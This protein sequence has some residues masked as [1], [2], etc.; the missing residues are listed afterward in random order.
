MVAKYSRRQFPPD[1]EMVQCPDRAGQI[2]AGHIFVNNKIII[3]N[4]Q[5]TMILAAVRAGEQPDHTDT[6]FNDAWIRCISRSCKV[7][8]TIREIVIPRSA[9]SNLSLWWRSS[10]TL[11]TFVIVNLFV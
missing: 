2:I 11:T 4:T 8:S 1:C 6:L 9:A 5:E 7:S 3:N 10:V